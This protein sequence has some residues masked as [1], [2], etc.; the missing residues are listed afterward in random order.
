M[1]P[2]SGSAAP[3]RQG[4]QRTRVVHQLTYAP[5]FREQFCLVGDA[6]I[7]TCCVHTTSNE[8]FSNGRS[9][10]VTLLNFYL[11]LE[12]DTPIEVIC[13]VTELCGQVDAR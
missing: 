8:L 4:C 1:E 7:V 3:V 13:H 12:T 6:F 2:E 11:V 10:R 9:K 5:H